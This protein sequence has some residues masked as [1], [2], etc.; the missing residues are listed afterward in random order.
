MQICVFHEQMVIESSGKELRSGGSAFQFSDDSV[1]NC[2][3][4]TLELMVYLVHSSSPIYLSLDHWDKGDKRDMHSF[5]GIIDKL[6]E[7]RKLTFAGITIAR[8][9]LCLQ[10][11]CA[12]GPRP[13]WASRDTCPNTCYFNTSTSQSTVQRSKLL[14]K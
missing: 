10:G 1:K 12:E 14:S 3:S 4:H 9:Y 2:Q 7:T 11:S 8:R 5:G 6:R 13:L